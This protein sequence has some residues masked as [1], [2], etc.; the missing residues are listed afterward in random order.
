MRIIVLQ[1]CLEFLILLKKI[2]P[3]DLLTTLTYTFANDKIIYSDSDIGTNTDISII[4]R[5]SINK[6]FIIKY[7]YG[8][9]DN[10]NVLI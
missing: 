4:V 1:K 3:S 6:L 10:K 2:C 7:K 8:Y 5:L 9:T